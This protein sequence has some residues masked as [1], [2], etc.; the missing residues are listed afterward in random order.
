MLRDRAAPF[1][2]TRMLHLVGRSGP[3]EVK[4]CAN[5]ALGGGKTNWQC[6]LG[7]GK[8]G[9]GGENNQ[10]EDS[11]YVKS[12]AEILEKQTKLVFLKD[13]KCLPCWGS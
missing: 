1:T 12:A 2:I 10:N 5:L 8:E 13:R 4:S 3:G 9:R 11:S 6:G 7:G